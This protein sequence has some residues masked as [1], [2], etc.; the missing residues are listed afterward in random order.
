MDNQTSGS[1]LLS[2]AI[3]GDTYAR[4]LLFSQNI[5][6]IWSVVKRFSNRGY[7]SDDLF[8]VGSIGLLKAIDNFDPSFDVQFSTYAVP[9]IMGE[10]KRF[11]RDDGMIKVSR[12]VKELAMKT[13]STTEIFEKK[14]G[15]TPT[16]SEISNILGCESEDVVFALYACQSHES[17]YNNDDDD[18]AL[19]LINKIEDTALSEEEIVDRLTLKQAINSLKYR[20]RQII[21]LRYFKGLTQSQIAQKLGISQVQ[22]SR[23]EKK[24]LETMK[25]IMTC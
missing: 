12:S 5:G 19:S 4:D 21:I 14:N 7:E 1:D 17:L 8:Q 18:K 6:L 25:K 3:M 10:I 24:V 9:M 16:I 22:V 13:K 23:I 2:K 15:R 11:L 20:E